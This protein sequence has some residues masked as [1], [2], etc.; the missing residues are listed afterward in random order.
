MSDKYTHGAVLDIIEQQSELTL[1]AIE[2]R[3]FSPG[4]PFKSGGLSIPET[5]NNRAALGSLFDVDGSEKNRIIENV[6]FENDSCSIQGSLVITGQTYENRIN[7]LTG[8]FISGTGLLWLDFADKNLRELDWSA[9]EHKLNLTNVLLSE[10]PGDLNDLIVYDLIDRGKFIDQDRVDII[11]RYPAF[12][13]AELL[14]NIFKGYDLKS[15]FLTASWFTPIYQMFT[16]TNEIRNDED[17]KES[18]LFSGDGE[19]VSNVNI[20]II[21]PS[22]PFTTTG[23]ANLDVTTDP[24]YDNGDNYNEA[25]DKYI[26]P[27]TGTYRFK[28]HIIGGVDVRTDTL[29]EPPYNT[30]QYTQL[31]INIISDNL[32]SIAFYQNIVTDPTNPGRVINMDLDLDSDFMELEAGDGIQFKIT[33]SGVIINTATGVTW[34]ARTYARMTVFDQ[35]SRY[36]GHGSTVKPS[37]ILPDIKVNDF[38]RIIF[39]HF[40]IMPQYSVETNIVRLDVWQRQKDGINLTY[41]LDPLTASAEFYEAF[42]YEL[43]FKP[44]TGDRYAEDWY[45]RN[46]NE[47]GTYKAN[48]GAKVFELLQTEYSNTVTQK[49]LRLSGTP[50]TIPVIWS[51]IPE[52]QSLSEVTHDLAPE[53]KTACNYRLLIYKGLGAGEYTLGGHLAGIGRTES[54][55]NYPVFLPYTDTLNIEFSDR[56]GLPG[57]HSRLHAALIARI[58]NGIV[59]TIQGNLPTEYL[60][61]LINN[62]ENANLMKAIYI[63]FEPF[64]GMWTIQR[65]TTNGIV[66]Q[67]SLIRNEE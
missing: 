53:W 2:Y 46:E 14:K 15:N 49:P 67:L 66:S 22:N 29:T 40:G 32:G 47:K 64:N 27:Q 48:N 41:S 10:S 19:A 36:Y 39:E 28:C 31:D 45:T 23:I 58:N 18:A 57:L 21:A 43:G 65:I 24:Y 35:V 6:L 8:F 17:W 7:T 61:D 26:V 16:G 62:D 55:E 38:L 25:T 37:E 13:V 59:L 52:V 54:T 20:P 9:Y 1:E 33:Y 12:N 11:E 63:G 44:D 50:D 51:E 60:T 56:N 42:N 34:T 4:K 30:L 5:S 3:S